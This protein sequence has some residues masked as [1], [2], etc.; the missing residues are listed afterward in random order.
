M[1]KLYIAD[2]ETVGS[3]L[4]QTS[5]PLRVPAWQRS[6]SWDTKEISAFW[7][8]IVNFSDMHPGKNLEK[9]QYF[10]GSVVLVEKTTYHEVLD[11]QQRLATATILL[12]ALRDVVR[13]EEAEAA[14]QIES[15]F[16][17]QYDIKSQST[18]FALRL[19]NYDA[20]FFRDSIQQRKTKLPEP[21]L[22]SHKR[23]AK[24][25]KYLR[26]EAQK[27]FDEAGSGPAASMR[28]SAFI[29]G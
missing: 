19:N 27:R 17:C 5:P 26:K 4:G 23:I 8:D 16:I 18:Q 7:E 22:A 12:A 9:T 24:A 25:Y 21:R 2:E 29:R 14:D 10:L 3:L 15:R 6:Y 13:D 20:D 11:G 28:S 1:A